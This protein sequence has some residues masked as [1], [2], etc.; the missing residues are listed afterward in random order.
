MMCDFDLHQCA[1][2]PDY[3][4]WEIINGTTGTQYTGPPSDHTTG[5]GELKG[6][7]MSTLKVDHG[8]L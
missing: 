5:A 6:L 3:S 7:G 8:I 1:F 4:D 2:D